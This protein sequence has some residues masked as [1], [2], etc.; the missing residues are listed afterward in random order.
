M[1]NDFCAFILSHGRPHNVTT[2]DKLR[3]HGYSGPIYIIIDNEDKSASGYYDKYG[4]EVIM[5]DKLAVSKTFDQA[6]NFKDRK[7]IVYARNFCF[8]IAKT[9][10]H[11]HFIQLDDD[12]YWFGLR[13]INGAVSTRNL[14]NIFS[15]LV[16]FLKE[17]NV[18][19]IAFSQGGDHIGGYDESKFVSRKAMNS[20]ICSTNNSFKF[21]GRINEDVNTYVKLGSLGKMFF[22]IRNIQ[23]DQKDTQSNT[24]GMSDVYFNSGTYI[25]SFYTILFSPSCV[26]IRL[27]G[28][29]NRRLHHS[30]SWKNAVPV[31]IREGHK[32]NNEMKLVESNNGKTR[33]EAATNG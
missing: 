9:L 25:K 26:K 10:G 21:I 4:D 29:H 23:L 3:Q 17:T 18:T 6:D 16:E 19:T 14:D 5:F 11:K 24:G 1:Q 20:F 12:Y 15:C 28:I 7:T 32:K 13:S 8:E 30:I 2:Y 22:T 31:I 27:M 33:T